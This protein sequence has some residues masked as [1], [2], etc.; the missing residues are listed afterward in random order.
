MRRPLRA[1]LSLSVVVRFVLRRPWS[2]ASCADGCHRA[3]H[4]P[5]SVSFVLP[6]LLSRPLLSVTSGSSVVRLMRRCTLDVARIA[7]KWSTICCHS[8]RCILSRRS[9]PS[10]PSGL[11]PASPASSV[12]IAVRLEAA[13]LL[14]RLRPSPLHGSKRWPMRRFR[15]TFGSSSER[16]SMNTD[17]HRLAHATKVTTR[18]PLLGCHDSPPKTKPCG[19]ESLDLALGNAPVMKR[20]E[21]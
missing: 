11:S 12:V 14:R 21:L 13:H 2:L 17:L 18:G 3:S 10:R 7:P 4:H 9:R 20:L 5:A 1:S 8:V 6:S 19:M 16:G 15:F